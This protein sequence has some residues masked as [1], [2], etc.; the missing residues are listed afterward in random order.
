MNLKHFP[1]PEAVIDYVFQELLDTLT[2][3]LHN[4]ETG[5]YF[6]HTDEDRKKMKDIIDDIQAVYD[7][8]GPL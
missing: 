4:M 1:N 5:D 8:M 6:L 3:D 7:T 2:D